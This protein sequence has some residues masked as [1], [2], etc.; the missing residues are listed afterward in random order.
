[1]VP[2][3]PDPDSSSTAAV[4]AA[5]VTY[6]QGRTEHERAALAHELHGELGG[7]LAAARMDL[8]WLRS[9]TVA[10]SPDVAARWERVMQAL[11]QGAELQRRVTERLRPA[12]LDHLGLMPALR[13]LVEDGSPGA[14]PQ[15]SIEGPEDLP[16][17]TAAAGIAVFRAV[18]ECLEGAKAQPQVK[19]IRVVVQSDADWLTVLI[20]DDGPG[21]PLDG[22]ES[23]GFLEFLAMRHRMAA[24]GGEL[25]V[26]RLAA[27]RGTEVQVRVPWKRLLASG[28]PGSVN[29]FTSS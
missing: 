5:L 29:H 2:L 27:P 8:A 16:V 23:P 6:L 17:L 11:A 15:A 12:L 26:R 14:G 19:Q 25:E 13:W 21:L 7:L 4:L 22:V 9:R 18:Q 3:P 1:M 28:T 10:E 24:L 20:A